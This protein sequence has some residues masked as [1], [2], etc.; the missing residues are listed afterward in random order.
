MMA[1]DIVAKINAMRKSRVRIG[2][3]RIACCFRALD[4]VTGKQ[5]TSARFQPAIWLLSKDWAVLDWV[6]SATV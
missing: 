6:L 3:P 1:L 4:E 2:P 5:Y